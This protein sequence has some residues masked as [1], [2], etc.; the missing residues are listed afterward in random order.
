MVKVDTDPKKIDEILFRSVEEVIPSREELKKKMLSGE[1]MRFYIG[2]DSTGTSLHLGHSTNY[3]ILE[4]LR[5]LGHEVV[6]L[7]GDF[8]SRIGDPTDKSDSARKQ[9]TREQV[10]EHT[11]TWIDQV[12]PIIDVDNK[13]NPVKILYNHDWLAKLTFEEVLSI[14][15][16]FTVQHMIERDMFQKRMAEGKPLYLHELFYPLMQGY[17]SV[18]MDVDAELCGMDQKFNA[19][20]GRILLKKLRNKEK[21]VFITTLL[22]NPVTGEKM[23]SKSMGTGVFLDFDAN[24]MYGAVM[25]QADENMKQ[26]FVDCTLL[27]FEDID[28]ILKAE[29]P[30]DAKMRLAREITTLYHGVDM[31]MHAEES[32]I[33]TFQKGGVPGEIEKVSVSIGDEFVEVLVRE[34]VVS[35]KTD[36]RRLVGAGAVEVIEGGCAGEKVVDV[37]AKVTGPVVLKVG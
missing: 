15:S 4:K 21:F 29:N 27:S 9:L 26:L 36:W 5:K 34:G 14:A 32:F 6:F 1:R 25:A 8:T 23:M 19:L 37:H 30:R 35:S 31:A 12:R 16:N 33:H 17:D 10:I 20:A 11:K 13:D 24:K 2:T 22:E 7:I 28:E 3:I 18:E